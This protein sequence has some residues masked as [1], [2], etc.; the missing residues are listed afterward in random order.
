M[1]TQSCALGPQIIYKK[2]NAQQNN[3]KLNSG[4]YCYQFY[5][6]LTRS[7]LHRRNE[8]KHKRTIVHLL[9]NCCHHGNAASSIVSPPIKTASSGEDPFGSRGNPAIPYWSGWYFAR[10]VIPSFLSFKPPHSDFE[11]SF[12]SWSNTCLVGRGEKTLQMWDLSLCMDI[13]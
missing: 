1:L 4:K 12:L 9:G 11:R 6:I 10:V 8:K 13:M 7:I 5:G 2:N 3:Q